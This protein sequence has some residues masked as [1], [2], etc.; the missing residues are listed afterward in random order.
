MFA[1]IG[2]LLLIVPFLDAASKF[3]MFRVS[4]T[5]KCRGE[6]VSG[7]IIMYDNNFAFTDH[8]LSEREVELDGTFSLR[9]EPAD[10]CLD[11]KLVVN[12]KCHDLRIGRGDG[13][14]LWGYSE[15]SIHLEDLIKNEYNVNMDIELSGDR[16]KMSSPTLPA[17]RAWLYGKRMISDTFARFKKLKLW[18]SV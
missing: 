14:K 1:L 12:H 3:P 15:Y 9:G 7:T 17:W 13:S 16:V 8:L 18:K 6:P 4:G 5:L 11:V 2:V 10:D